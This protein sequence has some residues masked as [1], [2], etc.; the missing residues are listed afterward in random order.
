MRDATIKKGRHSASIRKYMEGAVSGP[1]AV[2]RNGI[3]ART[4][5]LPSGLMWEQEHSTLLSGY[6]VG[7]TAVTWLE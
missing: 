4:N 3:P 6:G 7:M 1:E 2:C 5:N